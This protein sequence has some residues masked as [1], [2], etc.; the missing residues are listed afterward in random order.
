MTYAWNT[1]LWTKDDTS[2]Y[3]NAWSMREFGS[4][5]LSPQIADV[6]KRYSRLNFRAKHELINSTTYS[7]I[8]YRE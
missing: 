7:L 8:N 6:L 4:E 2:K 5:V 1:T 3:R